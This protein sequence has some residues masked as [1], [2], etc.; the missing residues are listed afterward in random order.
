VTPG[1]ELMELVNER[2][3]EAVMIVP[4]RWLVWLRVGT[5]F[6]VAIDET[7]ATIDAQVVRRGATIDPVS[8]TVTV[9]G[10][11]LHAESNLV[12]KI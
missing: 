8:Q 11:I 4:S 10:R 5:R 7:G 2:V 12:V 9:Y 6:T 3:L 1:A